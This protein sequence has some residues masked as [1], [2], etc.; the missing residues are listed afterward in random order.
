MKE[1]EQGV[2]SPLTLCTECAWFLGE[3]KPLVRISPSS[4]V[5]AN[6]PLGKGEYGGAGSE[7]SHEE[8]VPAVCPSW[9]S[10]V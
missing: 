1:A 4:S 10:G 2:Q 6:P 9:L 7:P 5:Q 3:F 8:G